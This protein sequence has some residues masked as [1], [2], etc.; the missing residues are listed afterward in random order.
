MRAV[1][2]LVPLFAALGA[3][4]DTSGTFDPNDHKDAG[5]GGG[6]IPLE[7]FGKACTYDPADPAH[8]NPTNQCFAGLTCLIFTSDGRYTSGLT[9]SAWEDQ[10]TVFEETPRVDVGTC[11]L[12]ANLGDQITC[13]AGTELKVLSTNVLAC[14]KD[15][16]TPV[17]CGRADFTCDAR[18]YDVTAPA[19]CVHQCH[20]DVPDCVRSGI[21]AV[22]DSNPPVLTP[23]LA[24]DDLA[25]AR[26]C[27]TASG[28]CVDVSA[29]GFSGPGEPCT[30]TSDCEP[31]AAC[32]QAPVLDAVLIGTSGAPV[33]SG[34]C[35][36]P[37]DPTAQIDPNTG[38][39]PC[40]QGYLCQSA[41]VLNLGFQDKAANIPGPI[42]IDLASGALAFRGGF[43]FHQCAQGVQGTCPIAGTTCGSLDEVRVGDIWN[44]TPMCL[45]E[46]LAN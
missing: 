21:V 43:C 24:F 6:G 22:P 37:C 4:C 8:P 36:S 35:A 11:T 19:Q 23:A 3:N 1:L 44:T 33:T 39:G 5:P 18:Y 25:G 34:F 42:V 16:N 31:G 12:V 17:D 28:T 20:F 46:T 41:G 10:F 9:L 32:M 29:P 14:I 38:A 15:C 13:P 27:D 45:P 30:K 40:T 26:E 7:E 2:V